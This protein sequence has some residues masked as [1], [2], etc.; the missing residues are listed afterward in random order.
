MTPLGNDSQILRD[1]IEGDLDEAVDYECDTVF[2]EPDGSPLTTLT[3]EHDSNNAPNLFPGRGAADA[4]TALRYPPE[5]SSAATVTNP[6]DEQQ[7]QTIDQ[8]EGAKRRTKNMAR[9]QD[10]RQYRFKPPTVE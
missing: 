4:L 5:L 10:H 1:L 6:L 2:V 8:E 9:L 7:Q 3:G